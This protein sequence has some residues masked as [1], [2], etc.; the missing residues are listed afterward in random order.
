MCK[1]AKNVI[2]KNMKVYFLIALVVFQMMC[3]PAV[4][5]LETFIGQS[6]EHLHRCA[7]FSIKQ[8]YIL[9]QRVFYYSVYF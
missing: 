8:I 3:R 2:Q 4:H 5:I 6:S 1:T 7:K 9:S